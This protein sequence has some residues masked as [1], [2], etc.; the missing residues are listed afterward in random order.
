MKIATLSNA[1]VGHTQRWVEYFRSRGHEVRVWSLE[2][3][4]VELG[5]FRLPCWPLPGAVRYPL[6]APALR[7]ALARFE[8][9]LVDA[10][11][12]PNYGLLGVL[13]G[14]RPL[15]VS[16]WGSDLLLARA[17]G[18][19]SR[20]RAGLVLERA[21]LVIADSENLAAAARALGAPESRVHAIPWGISR[22]LFHPGDAREAG[23]LLSTRQHEPIY[24]LPTLIEGAAQVM[25]RW[26]GTRLE[27]AGAGSLTRELERLAARRLP[28][29]RWRFTGLLTPAAMAASL[30]RA[31]IY[32]SCSRS[33]STSVSLLEAMAAGAVP[34]VSDLE[35]N[36]E[37][38]GEGDGARLF[39]PGD[40]AGLAQALERAIS[41]QA[42][43]EAA[44]ARNAEVIAARADRDVQ[45]AKIER[46][47]ERAV[48]S[49]RTGAERIPAG[50][51]R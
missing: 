1:S 21:D 36:R 23:L 50:G 15:S 44:R 32:V 42:W 19:L 46:L 24:D 43:C 33:D 26:A 12:V 17:R 16:A 45:M 10:H 11:Y 18:A 48:A 14:R 37:W 4:P 7:S 31:S 30:A 39:A 27:I 29:G 41:N 25:E 6:A 8:P 47:F 2:P 9:D 20:R 28:A 38:V 34:V 5:A 49:R 40:P 3:G 13:C 22:Q 51:P 35:G